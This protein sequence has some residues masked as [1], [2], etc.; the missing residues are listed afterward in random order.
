[1]DAS[2]RQ[3]YYNLVVSII[4]K[5][6]NSAFNPDDLKI[7]S[8]AEHYAVFNHFKTYS[9]VFTIASNPMSHKNNARFIVLADSLIPMDNADYPR[10]VVY[11]KSANC[12]EYHP[13]ISKKL[14]KAFPLFLHYNGIMPRLIIEDNLAFNQDVIIGRINRIIESSR[15]FFSAISDINKYL[16]EA[17][18]P[19]VNKP[20]LYYLSLEKVATE[21]LLSLLESDD[22]LCRE[23]VLS[24]FERTYKALFGVRTCW[25]NNKGSFLFWHNYKGA[26]YPC[27]LKNDFIESEYLR[28]SLSRQ[29]IIDYLN[30]FE[31]IPGGF[32]SLFMVSILP[33]WPTIGGFPQFDFFQ[34]M[35]N[36]VEQNSDLSIDENLNNYN[37]GIHPDICQCLKTGVNT[38]STIYIAANPVSDLNIIDYLKSNRTIL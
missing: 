38:C 28:F 21:L 18:I 37:W 7:M 8:V 4:E 27:K 25:G 36:Y 24:N 19:F 29:S 14:R 3:P 34:K 31:L 11:N 22:E 13:L 30:N 26:L 1:M 16:Y 15:S 9:N 2:P 33:N 12:L 32:L 6:C 10:G 23:F 17:T 35:I 20:H 5:E